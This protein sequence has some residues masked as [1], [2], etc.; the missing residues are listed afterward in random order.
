MKER[1]P[2]EHEIYIRPL[3]DEE[4]EQGLEAIK[5]AEELGK[6]ILARRNGKPLPSSWRLIRE[7]REKRSKRI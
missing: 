4:V 3:I 7:E 2:E 5:R 6:R 1:V